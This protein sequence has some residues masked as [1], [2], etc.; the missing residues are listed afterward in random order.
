M[1][2]LFGFDIKDNYKEMFV[3]MNV[4]REF[5]DTNYTLDPE[6]FFKKISKEAFD[7]LCHLEER[8][9]KFKSEQS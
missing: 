7:N 2:N 3:L 6:N 1:A 8:Y 4:P 9:N 5:D